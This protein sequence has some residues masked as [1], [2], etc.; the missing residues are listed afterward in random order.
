MQRTEEVSDGLGASE[1][2][3]EFLKD[4]YHLGK[5]LSTA[6]SRFS[7]QRDRHRESDLFKIFKSYYLSDESIPKTFDLILKPIFLSFLECLAAL[8]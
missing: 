8:R 3:G 4:A 6:T 7:V 2:V 5:P 1:S